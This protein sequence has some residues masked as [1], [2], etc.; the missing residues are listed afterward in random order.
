MN[1][2]VTNEIMVGLGILFCGFIIAM[3]NYKLGIGIMIYGIPA[4]LIVKYSIKYAPKP[5]MKLWM[6][7]RLPPMISKLGLTLTIVHTLLAVFFCYRGA[8]NGFGMIPIMQIDFPLSLLS[9]YLG[10]LLL[11]L[12]P[13][14]A[15]DQFMMY[16]VTFSIVGGLQWYGIGCLF[17][18]LKKHPIK[19]AVKA[20]PNNPLICHSCN[21][22][23]DRSWKV[24]LKCGKP[25]VEKQSDAVI[26]E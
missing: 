21:Q 1:K 17:D 19:F 7:I 2:K 22:D 14:Y 9:W 16:S 26:K 12:T 18:Y 4:Y 13:N 15:M 10:Q 6:E 8:G 20:N 24:C 5:I 11:G 23:Y 25:L 3:L